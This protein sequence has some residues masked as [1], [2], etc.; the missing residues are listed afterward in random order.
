MITFYLLQET[1]SSFFIEAKA[2]RYICRY[3]IRYSRQIQKP[4]S[5]AATT[6]KRTVVTLKKR[7]SSH[8]PPSRKVKCLLNPHSKA[9]SQVGVPIALYSK[10][11]RA[12]S[13]IPHWPPSLPCFCSSRATEKPNLLGSSSTAMSLATSLVLLGLWLPLRRFSCF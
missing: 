4:A 13:P 7:T 6:K 9:S 2:S 11:I 1:D 5:H 12:S 8:V 3:R 10:L